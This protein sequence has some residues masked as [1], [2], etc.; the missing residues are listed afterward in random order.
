[1]MSALAKEELVNR[2]KALSKEEMEI[3]LDNIPIELIHA[4]AGRRLQK[5]KECIVGIQ[6]ALEGIKDE[7]F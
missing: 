3:V 6:Q 2:T 5:S 7:C 4:A 1:M